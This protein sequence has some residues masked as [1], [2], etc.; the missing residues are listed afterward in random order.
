MTEINSENEMYGELEQVLISEEQLQ[1]RIKELGQ[2]IG[3]DY[4]GK[5]PIVIGILKGSALFM[6]DLVKSIPVHLTIDFMA[7]SSYSGTTSTGVVKIVKDLTE[8]IEGRHVIIAEDIID[9]GLTLNYLLKSLKQRNPASLTVCTLLNKEA[10]RLMPVEDVGY[11]GFDIDDHFVVGYGLDYMQKF[12]N[13]PCIGVLK[14]EV[15][16][17]FSA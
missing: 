11:I 14:P 9:T 5:T 13:L 16:Q 15:Y 17:K 2:Q 12:R 1:A 10:R 7:I 6:T 4:A 8:N 3:R